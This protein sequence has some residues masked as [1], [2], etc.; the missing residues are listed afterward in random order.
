MDVLV[1]GSG[2][3]AQSVAFDLFQKFQNVFYL[4]ALNLIRLNGNSLYR[5]YDL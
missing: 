1:Q 4:E 5:V 2:S 3:G